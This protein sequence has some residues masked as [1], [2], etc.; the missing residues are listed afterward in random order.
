MKI[1]AEQPSQ[2]WKDHVM[3]TA[4][5]PLKDPGCALGENTLMKAIKWVLKVIIHNSEVK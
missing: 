1:V 4:W 2:R 3:S 5:I